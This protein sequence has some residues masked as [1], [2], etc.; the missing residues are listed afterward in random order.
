LE[1]GVLLEEAGEE[2]A[3]TVAEDESAATGDELG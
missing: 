3:V 2:T 1:V